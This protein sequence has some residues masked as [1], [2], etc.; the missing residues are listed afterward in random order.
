MLRIISILLVALFL[1]SG[2][3]HA[4]P[5]VS[6]GDHY[7]RAAHA[8]VDHSHKHVSTDE[9][10]DLSQGDPAGHGHVH[11]AVD[12]AKSPAMRFGTPMMEAPEA[13]PVL[14]L[15]P[16]SARVPVDPPSPPIRA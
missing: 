11:P 16:W 15:S 4:S 10:G 13:G 2:A 3:L 14:R 7:P 12:L 9:S 5:P 1:V 6:S 8:Y